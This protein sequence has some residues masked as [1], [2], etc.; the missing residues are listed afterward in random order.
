[1]VNTIKAPAFCASCGARSA[2]GRFCG[3]CGSPLGEAP[4]DP[5]VPAQPAPPSASFSVLS[6]EQPTAPGYVPRAAS[7]TSPGSAP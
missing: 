3:D 7:A 6:S 5:E 4:R 1:M 2:G